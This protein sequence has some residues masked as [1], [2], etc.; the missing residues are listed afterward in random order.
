MVHAGHD[1]SR[2][3]NRAEVGKRILRHCDRTMHLSGCRHKRGKR[4]GSRYRRKVHGFEGNHDVAH[5]HGLATVHHTS[6]RE[7]R[8]HHHYPDL[9]CFQIV[10]SQTLAFAGDFLRRPDHVIDGARKYAFFG[11][12]ADVDVIAVRC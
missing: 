3:E 1:L 11:A 8:L 9:C 12:L 5:F 10:P 2:P 7:V 4:P 6:E